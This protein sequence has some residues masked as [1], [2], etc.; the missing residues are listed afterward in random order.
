MISNRDKRR[1][2]EEELFRFQIQKELSDEKE[3]KT[4]RGKFL[5]FFNT[6]F[7]LWL[8]SSIFLSLVTWGY[9][10]WQA[11]S[12][13]EKQNMVNKKRLSDE[14]S[15]RIGNAYILTSPGRFEE[16]KNPHYYLDLLL[17]PPG[18]E[19]VVIPEFSN[20]NLSSLLHE[21]K[22]N[23]TGYEK[24]QTEQIEAKV[25]FIVT[26]FPD[27]TKSKVD[28]DVLN[29]QIQELLRITNKSEQPQK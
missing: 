1:I 23:L 25:G 14:I 8:L 7:G 27:G 18:D 22:Q 28:L 3:L 24:S 11:K 19:R 29:K 20:R 17:M 12:E 6:A 4:G 21:L 5:K 13:I 9:S 16:N 10:T 26:A 2:R 15:S